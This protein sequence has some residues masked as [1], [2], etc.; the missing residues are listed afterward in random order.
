MKRYILLTAV[1]LLF[2]LVF[3][4]CSDDNKVDISGYENE[5]I[6]VVGLSDKELSISVKELTELE[7]VSKTTTS[8]SNKIGKV[9]AT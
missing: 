4:S 6:T 7:C 5:A 1:V 2:S 3:L 8:T 9:T